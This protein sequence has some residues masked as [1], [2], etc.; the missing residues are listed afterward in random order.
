MPYY[1]KTQHSSN[2]YLSLLNWK[3]NTKGI[4]HSKVPP[5][6]IH[7]LWTN[8]ILMISESR[9][10]SATWICA[11]KNL[12]I[13]FNK[14]QTLQGTWNRTSSKLVI[15]KGLVLKLTA[16]TTQTTHSITLTDYKQKTMRLQYLSS[17][18]R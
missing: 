14:N 3:L 10:S 7:L 8:S 9:N 16:L 11:T 17:I 1:N 2:F 12:A 15:I 6:S 13:I 18:K 5:L 4:Q